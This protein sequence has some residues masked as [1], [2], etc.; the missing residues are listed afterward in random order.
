[1]A[2]N[3][4]AVVNEDGPNL[5]TNEEDQVQVSLH[6]ANE[7]EDMVWQRLHEP[8][9]WVKSQRSPGRGNNPFV[10]WLVDVFVH[11]RVM[12]QTMNPVDGNIVETHVQDGRDHKPGPAI[13]ACVGVK[14]TFATDLGQKYRQG[15]K[16]DKR[17]R[18]ER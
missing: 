17:D 16:V 9:K 2:R 7:N 3:H 5:D 13:V 1:M 18:G 15:Q 12:F 14:Q 4:V 11:A 8:I 10:V 6:W